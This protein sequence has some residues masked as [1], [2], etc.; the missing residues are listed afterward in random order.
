MCECVGVCVQ[1]TRV[2]SKFFAI[3]EAHAQAVVVSEALEEVIHQELRLPMVQHLRAS[4]QS[5][6]LGL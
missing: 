4:C 5:D 2:S 1:R 3:W 6:V